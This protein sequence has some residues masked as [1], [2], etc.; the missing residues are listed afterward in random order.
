[1]TG[2]KRG[3]GRAYRKEENTIRGMVQGKEGREEE[4]NAK[5]GEKKTG[6]A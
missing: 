5:L 3:R 2:R 4:G 6:A 1:M